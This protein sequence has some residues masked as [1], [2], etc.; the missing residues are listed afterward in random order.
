[1]A[2]VKHARTVRRKE[3]GLR[4]EVIRAGQK[5]ESLRG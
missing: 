3:Q 5:N 1:V 2:A 4:S